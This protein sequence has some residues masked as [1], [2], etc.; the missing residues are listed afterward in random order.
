M[1]TLETNIKSL[2]S[3]YEGYT[4]ITPIPLDF[5][6]DTWRELYM[7]YGGNGP[8]SIFYNKKKIISILIGI[9]F[10]NFVQ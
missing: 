8:T 3:I 7:D 4:V 1:I 5:Q 9:N 2:T 6:L 10:G